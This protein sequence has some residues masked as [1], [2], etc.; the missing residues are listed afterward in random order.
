M[1]LFQLR[2]WQIERSTQG[3]GGSKKSASL[4]YST[5]N[6]PTLKFN[7]ILNYQIV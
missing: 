4:D 5:L 3:Q 1:Q 7:A 2:V 6:L